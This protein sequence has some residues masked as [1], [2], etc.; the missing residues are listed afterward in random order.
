MKFLTALNGRK[1]VVS[2]DSCHTWWLIRLPADRSLWHHQPTDLSVSKGPTML[3]IIS[4]KHSAHYMEGDVPRPYIF[5]SCLVPRPQSRIR[6]TP[7]ACANMVPRLNRTTKVKGIVAFWVRPLGESTLQKRRQ[8][9]LKQKLLWRPSLA[10]RERRS[11]SL[12]EIS[13]RSK[14]LVSPMNLYRQSRSSS[15]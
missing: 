4:N 2:H 13:T 12:L 3:Y 5:I 14:S 7:C 8:W 9:R 15:T 11:S 10:R 1:D 6:G